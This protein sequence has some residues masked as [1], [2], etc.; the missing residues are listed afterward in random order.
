MHSPLKRFPTPR[1]LPAQT[2]A[3]RILEIELIPATV[4][5]SPFLRSL[6]RAYRLSELL[7]TPWTAEQKRAFL[8]DQFTLQHN[9]YVKM[10]SKGDYH[11]IRRAGHLV[12]RLS[13]DRSDSGWALV[14]ILLTADARSHGIGTALIRWLQHSAIA[15]G[16]EQLRLNVAHNNPR[17]RKLYDDLGFR[18]SES[19]ATHAGMVWTSPGAM[20]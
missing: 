7:M 13:F 1:P 18:A 2:E 15:A 3:L 9:H 19:T 6:Y 4:A 5:D 8:D 12:G 10:Y 16:A 17:A 20:P 14:D 11:L